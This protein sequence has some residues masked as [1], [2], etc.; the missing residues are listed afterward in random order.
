MFKVSVYECRFFLQVLILA[1]MKMLMEAIG[2]KEE[3]HQAVGVVKM[4]G[5]REVEEEEV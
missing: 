3:E 2:E 1:N 5:R 4:K